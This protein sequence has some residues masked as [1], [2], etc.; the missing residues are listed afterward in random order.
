[1]RRRF[2]TATKHSNASALQDEHGIRRLQNLPLIA[3]KLQRVLQCTGNTRT[4]YEQLIGVELD[5][6]V[7]YTVLVRIK[8]FGGWRE[9]SSQR[10]S[11]GVLGNSWCW[12]G[13]LYY[14]HR[15]SVLSK[16]SDPSTPVLYCT[17]LCCTGSTVLLPGRATHRGQLLK[18]FEINFVAKKK[19]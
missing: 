16:E 13:G 6:L 7:R 14:L 11:A 17:V 2:K 9:V 18:I 12:K 5:Q 19:A 8:K 4:S 10:H 3:S 15:V 1:M